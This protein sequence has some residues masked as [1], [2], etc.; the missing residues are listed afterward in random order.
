[1]PS[2]QEPANADTPTH[3]STGKQEPVKHDDAAATETKQEP[4][5]PAT[6]TVIKT[7]I[8]KKVMRKRLKKRKS[9]EEESSSG[10]SSAGS[11]HES[12]P[13]DEEKETYGLAKAA[14]PTALHVDRDE[15]LQAHRDLTTEKQYAQIL[16]NLLHRRLAEYYK[17]RKCEHVLKPFEG[18]VELEEK[19]NQ[20][21]LV[22]DDM[23]KKAEMELADVKSKVSEVEEKYL[24]RLENANSKF[25]ELQQLERQT[26][27]G[28]IYS[29]KGKPMTDKT[30]ERFLTLQRRKADQANALCLRHIRARNAV[31]ELEAIVKNL[32]TLGPGL[33]VYQYEQ[34]NVDN[35]NYMTKIEE[36]EDELIKH[37]T[38][39]TEHNQILAH[40]REKMHHTDEV[41]DCAECDLGDAEM[42]FFAAREEL[43]SVKSRRNKLRWSLEDER[44][45]AGLL[46]RKDLLR[47]FQASLD[48]VLK[49]EKKKK[50]LEAQVCKTAKNLREARKSV[51]IHH[52]HSVQHA[53]QKD[54][55]KHDS[56]SKD[57]HEKCILPY[58][59]RSAG[60]HGR[61]S[62]L[63]AGRSSQQVGH[64]SVQIAIETRFQQN[65]EHGSEHESGHDH[66]SDHG[67]GSGD[68]A[69]GPGHAG[70]G[71]GHHVHGLAH[72]G[73]GPDQHG[74]GAEHHG[75]S[76]LH[77]LRSSGRYVHG[78]GL[79]GHHGAH[80]SAP[81]Q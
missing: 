4:A 36:R 76:P 18:D 58:H 63:I 2:T 42:D 65:A 5:K 68:H 32:E 17:K 44:L 7:K 72:L 73:H 24:A 27:S 25:H 81:P 46:T 52:Q 20:K 31:S 49:L 75:L 64:D 51:Q 9:A 38:K 53:M 1:M 70:G 15:Y 67:Y 34:L 29:R 56:A 21:L 28:L 43:S 35:Q 69:R 33:Y 57:G 48:E 47:D 3:D 23:K 50:N 16:N 79:H 41:I 11:S 30:V 66:V 55:F 6:K 13:E 80:H 45:K 62:S 8:I 78:V 61:S 54:G 37:R 22:Y 12:A 77:H 71:P 10:T 14:E 26:G 19:Y 40:I 59:R 39:C 74:H 60:H